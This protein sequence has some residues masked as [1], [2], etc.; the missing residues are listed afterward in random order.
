MTERQHTSISSGFTRKPKPDK[1]LQYERNHR[2]DEHSPDRHHRRRHRRP[3]HCGGSVSTSRLIAFKAASRCDRARRLARRAGRW[4]AVLLTLR[5]R[6]HANIHDMLSFRA[7]RS[8]SPQPPCQRVRLL[9][10]F[11]RTGLPRL[12]EVLQLPPKPRK[13]FQMRGFQ[14]AQSRIIPA[15]R[16]V[17]SPPPDCLPRSGINQALPWR[18]SSARPPNRTSM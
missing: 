16:L 5:R 11:S 1:A 13:L 4:A 3:A 12:F 17:L 18:S 15:V 8:F 2:D 14:C 6:W 7:V 9:D 10:K